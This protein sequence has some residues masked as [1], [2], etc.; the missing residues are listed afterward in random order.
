MFG[1]SGIINTIVIVGLIVL[2]V[3]LIKKAYW[4]K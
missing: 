4:K 3:I 1:I 2:L